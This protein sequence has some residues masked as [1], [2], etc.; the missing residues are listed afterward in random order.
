VV[1]DRFLLEA[2]WH[3]YQS[4]KTVDRRRAASGAKTDTIDDIAGK[5]GRS[6]WQT[7]G[8]ETDSASWPD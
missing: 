4:S 6:D 1:C 7:W 3:V 5:H 8:V 2:G